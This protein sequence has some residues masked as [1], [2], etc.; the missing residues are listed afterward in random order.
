M[1][2]TVDKILSFGSRTGALISQFGDDKE[3]F[4]D[5]TYYNIIKILLIC[6]ALYLAMS[7]NSKI[8]AAGVQIQHNKALN[9]LAAICCAPCYIVYRLVSPC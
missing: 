8:N 7:C 2:S 4:G 6:I 1:D 3:K 9:L 5:D